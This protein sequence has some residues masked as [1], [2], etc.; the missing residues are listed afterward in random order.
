MHQTLLRRDEWKENE[1]RHNYNYK[2]Y[3]M[4]SNKIKLYFNN[5]IAIVTRLIILFPHLIRSDKLYLKLKYYTYF[6]HWIDFDAPKTFNEKLQWLKIYDRRPDYVNMVDKS[7]AKEYAAKIVG[8]KY[9]IPTLGIFD[10]VD[11]IDF[12]KL[13]NQFVLKC[14]HDSGGII[15][16]KNKASLNIEDVKRKLS[17]G[18]RRN[19]YWQT[20]EWPYKEVKPRI[21]AEKYMV[22]ESGYELKDYKFFCFNSKC[23]IFK[24]DFDRQIGHHANYY[25]RNSELLP[26]GEVICPPLFTKKVEIPSN[27]LEMMNMAEFISNEIKCPFVRVD[28]YNNNGHV[29]FG[30]ITFYPAS[31]IGAF[32]PKEWDN[33]LGEWLTLPSK[34]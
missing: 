34:G 28:L 16:C 1:N 24:I 6:H 29:Y 12:E 8:E 15:I 25:N 23:K 17:K 33:K 26:F 22:D 9:I 30:E 27:I 5:P 19:F 13:P 31:G 21:I 2:I 3:I 32:V 18:L 20:R 14:T 7:K 11:D 10:T 4:V